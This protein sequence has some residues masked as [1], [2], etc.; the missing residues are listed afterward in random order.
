MSKVILVIDDDPAQR[1]LIEGI[2]GASGYRTASASDGDSGLAAA[3]AR[4]PDLIILDVLMPG[5]NGYQ[6]C[7][8]LRADGATREVPILILTAKGEEADRFWAAQVGASAFLGKPVE[9]AELLE[10]VAGL[11]GKS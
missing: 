10:A 5:R 7:R 4:T 1:R 6:T 11:V 3:R 2:L 9:P 8:A